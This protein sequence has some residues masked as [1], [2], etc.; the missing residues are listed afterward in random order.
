MR[1]G[2]VWGWTM[3]HKIVNI[4]DDVATSLQERITK[5]GRSGLRNIPGENVERARVEQLTFAT[6]LSEH[7]L[8]TKEAVTAAIKGLANC[9]H[10]EL[11]KIFED[12]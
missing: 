9:S 12:Y 8:L 4:T 3:L 11:S 5:F 10:K 7:G 1:G 6:R 2:V